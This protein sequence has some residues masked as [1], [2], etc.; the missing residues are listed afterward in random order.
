M[1]DHP[2][3]VRAP[4]FR[5]V[6]EVPVVFLAGPIQGAPLW[7]ED[8]AQLIVRA[9]P[10]IVVASPRRL[11]L[12]RGQFTDDDY[13]AQVDWET[14]YL[15]R[16]GEHGCVLFWLAAEDHVVPGRQYAQT[17]R[18][19]LGEWKQMA[20]RHQAQLAL[21]IDPGFTNNRYISRRFGQD[22]PHIPIFETLED[23]CAQAATLAGAL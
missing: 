6:G 19:E 20:Q 2:R 12:V 21:G 9:H 16:A 15:R 5:D 22:C 17:T 23:V 14:T 18:F 3:I 4:E 11:E 7:Q 13:A 1:T 8:A 10:D